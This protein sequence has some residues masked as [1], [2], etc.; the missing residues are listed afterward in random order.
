MS[1]T[2]E[3]P[4]HKIA[5]E[6][7]RIHV[8]RRCFAPHTGQD[9]AAGDT[10]ANALRLYG[11][12]D[13]V[14]QAGAIAAMVATLHSAQ[15]TLLIHTT[16]VNA[17]PAVLYWGFVDL[18]WPAL[19]SPWAADV[20]QVESL[21]TLD[22]KRIVLYAPPTPAELRAVRDAGGI[23]ATYDELRAIAGGDAVELSIS[24][25]RVRMRI[26]GDRGGE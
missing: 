18:I 21:K 8:G 1:R 12:G 19:E 15:P 20:V 7:C 4:A 2:V 17:I 24:I 16:F 11:R 26:T 13:H 10:F 25:D 5:A 23:V 22:R 3:K 14:G 6:F 9:L